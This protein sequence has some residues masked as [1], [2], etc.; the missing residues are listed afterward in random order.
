MTDESLAASVEVDS[1]CVAQFK[2]SG[3]E[4]ERVVS[5]EL[6]PLSIRIAQLYVVVDTL[7]VHSTDVIERLLLLL[8]AHLAHA[9]VE[10]EGGVLHRAGLQVNQYCLIAHDISI[11]SAYHSNLRSVT[12]LTPGEG[13]KARC[14]VYRNCL[15]AVTGRRVAL[16]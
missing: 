12:H 6:L 14:Q 4:H 10:L 15:P 16:N 3:V 1:R 5:F 11:C 7:R 13:C 2:L 9:R 8:V